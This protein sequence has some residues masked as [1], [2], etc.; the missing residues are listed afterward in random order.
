VKRCWSS[1]PETRYIPPLPSPQPQGIHPGAVFSGS[2]SA[3][4]SPASIAASPLM[5]WNSVQIERLVPHVRPSPTSPS[6]PTPTAPSQN[7]VGVS[8]AP[9]DRLEDSCSDGTLA[10]VSGGRAPP[11]RPRAPDIPAGP[12]TCGARPSRKQGANW[13]QSQCR[14]AASKRM[15]IALSADACMHFP[16]IFRVVR[17]S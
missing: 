3:G 8:S 5:K 6:L 17:F 15:K 7:A 14:A 12:A 16:A 13:C 1:D 2:K 11:H 9:R 10:T 4:S